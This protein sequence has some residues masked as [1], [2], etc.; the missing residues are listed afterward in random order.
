MALMAVFFI[1]ETEIVQIMQNT[2][3]QQQDIQ[4]HAHFCC[5]TSNKIIKADVIRTDVTITDFIN[6]EFLLLHTSSL[7]T[8]SHINFVNHFITKSIHRSP[9]LRSYKCK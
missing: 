6:T 3:D 5:Q 7:K 4:K 1:N 2:L 8:S 9:Q